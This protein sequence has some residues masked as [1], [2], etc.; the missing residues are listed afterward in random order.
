MSDADKEVESGTSAIDV[1]IKSKTSVAAAAAADGGVLAGGKNKKVSKSSGNKSSHPRTAVM[2]QTAI[3]K[4]KHRN[5]S[6]VQAIKKYM[7]SNY[8][9]DSEKMAPFIKKYLKS[10]VASGV[11]IQTKGKGASGS[12]KLGN[13]AKAPKKTISL[14]KPK[15]VT[16]SK[17]RTAI[18]IKNKESKSKSS[19]S[20]T[21][22]TTTTTTTM[23]N[24]KKKATNKKKSK[25]A[26]VVGKKEEIKKEKSPK[27]SPLKS[28]GKS[29]K[30]QNSPAKKAPKPKSTKAVSTSATRKK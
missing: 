12:F 16:A 1:K 21:T 24:K 23:S 18:N 15:K 8:K 4:L 22:T 9:I 27:R 7:S 19:L 14:P 2:V 10:G 3:L 5:G 13:S 11:L 26:K 20:T 30:K 6:S 28:V 17:A 25:T 29:T